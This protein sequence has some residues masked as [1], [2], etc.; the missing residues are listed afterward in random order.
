VPQRSSRRRSRRARGRWIRIAALGA[1][2]TSIVG[3]ALFY[4]SRR[5]SLVGIDAEQ[6]E[7]ARRDFDQRNFKAAI[8]K[9]ENVL[10]TDRHNLSV[11]ILVGRS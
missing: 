10:A 2:V 5:S 8:I 6:Y 7:Q 1:F 9:L 3:G 4:F 11:Q